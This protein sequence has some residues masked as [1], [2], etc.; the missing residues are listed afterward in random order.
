AREVAARRQD[1]DDTI[2][3]APFAGVI[4]TKDAQPGEMISPNSAGGGFT[5]TGIGTLVDMT[6][7]EIDVDVN[8]SYINRV[9]SGQHAE[10]VLDA[11]PDWR[12]PA[13]VIAVVPS[14]DRQ[15]AT[16]KVRLAFDR[17]DPRLLPDMG[18][19]VAFLGEGDRQAAL[20]SGE[21][22][23]AARALARVPRA[24]LRQDRGQLVAFVVRGDR[25]ERRAVRITAAPGDEA[26]VLAGLTPGEQVVVDGPPDLADGRKVVV[27]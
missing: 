16:V 15:K 3:R 2:I 6:S 21:Q 25:V 24:A 10:A 4:T 1:V 11:Y 22:P 7:L 26:A 5:R 18:V 20:P 19:K 23:G 14:A 17:L 27:R 12:I 8:E 9:R 13:T